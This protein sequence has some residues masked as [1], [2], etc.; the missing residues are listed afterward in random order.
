MTGEPTEMTGV[1]L[2]RV[3]DGGYTTP[4]GRF[5]VQRNRGRTC[6]PSQWWAITDT[7]MRSDP[8]VAMSNLR[9]VKEW[10]AQWLE[11]GK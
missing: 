7:A 10:I 6:G 4:D 5:R 11:A 2:I 9:L 3:P 8:F 1:E